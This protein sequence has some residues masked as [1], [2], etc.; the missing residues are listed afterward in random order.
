MSDVSSSVPARWQF[1]L[2]TL[3]L[4]MLGAGILAGMWKTMGFLWFSLA[5]IVLAPALL[6]PRAVW[7]TFLLSCVVVYAPFAVMATYTQ[8]YVACS[9]CKEATLAVLP[10]GPGMIPVDLA[11]RWID[12]SILDNTL[13]SL[14]SFL[15]S[16]AMVVGLTWVLRMRG[17]WW[18]AIGVLGVLALCSFGAFVVLALIR[19]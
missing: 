12:L 18:Q 8:L 14:L 4:S 3:L 16:I 5:A 13:W 10:Y 15:A 11:R 6:L 2:R 1:S 17:P 9:H 7:A 19:A